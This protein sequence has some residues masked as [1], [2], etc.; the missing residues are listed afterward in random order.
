MKLS[1][2]MWSFPSS[3]LKF[4]SLIISV[5]WGV[6]MTVVTKDT[7]TAPSNSC[8]EYQ[9]A[10][11]HM[12]FT[13]TKLGCDIAGWSIGAGAG[14]GAFYIMYFIM[15]YFSHVL[16][17]I[18]DTLFMCFLMDRTRGVVMKPKINEV[19]EDVLRHRKVRKPFRSFFN[20]CCLRLSAVRLVGFVHVTDDP[21]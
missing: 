18:V 17:A 11:E 20:A 5:L 16:L 4:Y 14:A 6:I 8:V 19:I 12:L 2:G 13:T 21:F 10:L 1:I 7:V 15:T 9:D 3:V